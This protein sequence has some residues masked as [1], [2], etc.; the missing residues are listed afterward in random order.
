MLDGARV[1]VQPGAGTASRS[2]FPL[3]PKFQILAQKLAQKSQI[4]QTL[5]KISSKM[6]QVPGTCRIYSAHA[7]SFRFGFYAKSNAGIFQLA[8]GTGGVLAAQRG[9]TQTFHMR[10]LGKAVPVD[11]I[12]STLK[13]PGTNPSTLKHGEPLS[14]FAFKFNLRRYTSDNCTVADTFCNMVGRC[15]LSL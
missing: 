2:M 3:L 6:P 7:G 10:L 9:A 15:R 11:P 8:L 13:A 5:P 12:K 1:R 14:T 4:A